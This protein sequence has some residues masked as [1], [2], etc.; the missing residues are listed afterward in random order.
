MSKNSLTDEQVAEKALR[1]YLIRCHRT[2]ADEYPE[3]RGMEP[4]K[5]ADFIL[6]L[7]RTGRIDV[8][9]YMKDQNRIG[10]RIMERD[11]GAGPEGDG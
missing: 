5:A 8:Q 6:H 3:I 1:S 7:R 9:L 10:C 2:V 11:A 4:E